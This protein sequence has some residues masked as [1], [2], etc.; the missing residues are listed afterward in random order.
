MDVPALTPVI[1][2]ESPVDVGAEPA[3]EVERLLQ[4]PPRESS[5][6]R[7]V[8]STQISRLPWIESG[9]DF[10]VSVVSTKQPP[11]KPPGIV[12]VIT[13]VPG[14]TPYRIPLVVSMVAIEV[15]EL[16]HL[17]P[18]LASVRVSKEP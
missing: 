16:F 9:T 15:L 1:M 7:V 5:V 12:Y 18:R 11:L 4:T 8:P 2:V 14:D 10:T 13:V 17:P 6:R 3:M